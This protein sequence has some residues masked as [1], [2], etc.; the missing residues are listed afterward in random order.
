MNNAT[1]T[2]NSINVSLPK[3]LQPQNKVSQEAVPP[4]PPLPIINIPLSVPVSQSKPQNKVSIPSVQPLP[5]TP[6]SL[7]LPIHENLNK[8]NSLLHQLENY[9]SQENED[10]TDKYRKLN[11]HRAKIKK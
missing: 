6:L 8:N 9:V 4:I 5:I 1:N 3:Q 11:E 7:T 2:V 10:V